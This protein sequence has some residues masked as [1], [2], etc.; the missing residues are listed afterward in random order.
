MISGLL[1]SGSNGVLLWSG[2]SLL[3]ALAFAVI[4]GF[5]LASIV[6]DCSR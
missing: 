1:V 5:G 3:E 2:T 4:F 6:R